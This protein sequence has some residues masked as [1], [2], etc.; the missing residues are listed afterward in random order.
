MWSR[1][2]ATSD[3]TSEFIIYTLNLYFVTQ[4]ST[5]LSQ[6]I[7][8][9][10]RNFPTYQLEISKFRH[11]YFEILTYLSQNSAKFRHINS[12]FRHALPEISTYFIRNFDIPISNFRLFNSNDILTYRTKKFYKS[13]LHAVELRVQSVGS[14]TRRCANVCPS[15]KDCSRNGPT[16]SRPELYRFH[17]SR[18][19]KDYIYCHR[20]RRVAGHGQI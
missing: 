3:G 11:T 9:P 12:K 17:K 14:V 15:T 7:D 16:L 5:H 13:Q 2:D 19:I 18:L 20:K 8:I 1:N 4:L 6:K 10:N